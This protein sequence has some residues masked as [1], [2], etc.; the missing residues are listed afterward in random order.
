M[1]RHT[2]HDYLDDATDGHFVAVC[3][4]GTD[5]TAVKDFSNERE[6]FDVKGCYFRKVNISYLDEHLDDITD[7]R[8]FTA[9][10]VDVDCLYIINDRKTINQIMHEYGEELNH[11]YLSRLNR[12][13]IRC[14]IIPQP[15]T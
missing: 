7:W 13:G 4:G 3:H 6:L 15:P 9:K 5:L 12:D 14:V 8:A 10:L 11:K 1:V 2:H